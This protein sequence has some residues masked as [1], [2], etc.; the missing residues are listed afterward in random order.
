M[1]YI[2]NI[3]KFKYRVLIF[4]Y[5]M[6]AAGCMINVIAYQS[7]K[8]AVLLIFTYIT[9]YLLMFFLRT[10]RPEFDVFTR[11][12]GVGWFVAGI[13]GIYLNY[14]FDGGQNAN[15][16]FEFATQK[17]QGLSI[18]EIQLLSEGSLAIKLW[19]LLY[20]FFD[21]IGIGKERYVGV[22]LNILAVSLAGVLTVKM[23]RL[24]YGNDFYRFKI[25]GIML[26]S[27]GILWLFAAT[28]IRDAFIFLTVTALFYSWV[29]YYNK[30]RSIIVIVIFSAIYSFILFF[31]RKEFV[32]IPPA[33]LL[34]SSMYYLF[35]GGNK[36]FFLY[37]KRIA[38]GMIVVSILLYFYND[39]NEIILDRNQ[40]YSESSINSSQNNSLGLKLIVR[41][42][43]LI[44]AFLG[45]MYI[46]IFP[47][48]LWS[49]FQLDSVYH[50]FKSLNAIFFYF[51]IPMLLLSGYKLILSQ[52]KDYILEKFLF[53]SVTLMLILV[54]ITSLESRHFSVFIA[55]LFLLMLYPHLR[56]KKTRAVYFYVLFIFM[57]FLFF[58]HFIWIFVKFIY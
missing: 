36:S 25:L 32:F 55:P 52:S 21:V 8:T 28:H 39:V 29:Y 43:L 15:M 53:I 56:D 12:Y 18:I 49:G 26:S 33:L 57:F 24:M 17:S 19:S 4:D 10:K 34:I 2:E 42:G 50:L 22:S 46:L 20:D 54:A 11:T 40:L 3:H 30:S 45:S 58:G 51:T 38:T 1:R 14:F 31:L 16:F 5:F 35:R 13:S 47:I 6:L 44:R 41:Q 9:S 37:S 48:P 23:S 7:F 27:C